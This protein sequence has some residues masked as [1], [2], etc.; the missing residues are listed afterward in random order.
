M[1]CSAN[2]LELGCPVKIDECGKRIS[3]ST[4]GLVSV[5]SM[6]AITVTSATIQFLPFVSDLEVLRVAID[7][8][9]LTRTKFGPVA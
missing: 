2:Q 5:F 7:R 3:E 9:F 8:E 4:C 6:R 1:L